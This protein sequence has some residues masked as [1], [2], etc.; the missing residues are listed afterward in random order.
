MRYGRLQSAVFL[1]WIALGIGIGTGA[2][3][4]NTPAQPPATWLRA[5]TAQFKFV[6]EKGS[7]QNTVTVHVPVTMTPPIPATT[8]IALKIKSVRLD[9]ASGTNLLPAFKNPRLDRDSSILLLD[10]DP[11]KAAMPGIYAVSILA[12]RGTPQT[13]A[14][15]EV[16][17]DLQFTHPPATLQTIPPLIVDRDMI[18]FGTTHDALTPLHLMETS[19]KSRLTNL[20]F[21]PGSFT[22]STTRAVTGS[23]TL[24][25]PSS[26]PA[27]GAL[28]A[29]YNFTGDFA[30]GTTRGTAELHADQLAAPVTVTFEIHTRRPWW[31]LIPILVLGL[32]AG[33]FTRVFLQNRIQL[34]Q[35]R[36][37]GEDLLDRIQ[38]EQA[39]HPD[40]KFTQ[41]L[42][43]PTE[44]L[45]AALK[46]KDLGV[47][48][49][50]ITEAD[51]ALRAALT[52]LD[53]RRAT[54]QSSLDALDKV[55]Q[56]AW[57]I[58]ANM[59]GHLTEAQTEQA[60]VHLLLTQDALQAAQDKETG[61]L[62]TLRN[63]LSIDLAEWKADTEIRLT[64]L[65]KPDVP[66]PAT[67]ATVLNTAIGQLLP[68]VAGVAE[69]DMTSGAG[70]VTMTLQAVHNVTAQVRNFLLQLAG[71][72][73]STVGAFDSVL[74]SIGERLPDLP[75]I[76]RFDDQAAAFLLDL[77]AEA[78]KTGPMLGLLASQNL[79]I[80]DLSWQKA[81]LPQINLLSSSDQEVVR[82]KVKARQYI[83]AAESIAAALQRAE[84]ILE[85]FIPGVPDATGTSIPG[86]SPVPQV[87]LES[88]LP[89][90]AMAQMPGLPFRIVRV[91]SLPPHTHIGRPKTLRDL[92][93]SKA[94]QTLI[95]GIL[96]LVVGVELYA[97]KFVG[98]W[99]EMT[100]IFFWAFG[101]DVTVDA[102][103]QAV[104][105]IKPPT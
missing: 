52:A 69:I 104:K 25:P 91:E 71:W 50:K 6:D 57:L 79:G 7:T 13:P 63:K 95:L 53:A 2:G 68:L 89:G 100:S 96:I 97:D 65:Q 45:S 66:L 15:T 12:S 47:M 43:R 75:A 102:I 9:D 78:H 8:P 103:A 51:N 44:D 31:L 55:F 16:R 60:N 42:K 14:F 77:R 56:T 38:N 4:E 36:L 88:W 49:G 82:Q 34:D 3:G 18:P 17:L 67:V 48:G 105:G 101:L 46:E 26:L 98:A 40:E 10:I 85:N 92:F 29:N 41:D 24:K 32:G 99:P 84:T 76:K 72:V 94:W 93:L 80:L 22:D 5:D 19:N 90:Q 64:N 86:V 27:G 70:G 33:Y 35:M 39:R 73:E 74:T 30:L 59:Q 81:I 61:I 11:T 23:V 54:V 1:L 20:F 37:K 58:P 83:E 87:L 62:N 28:T 21:S